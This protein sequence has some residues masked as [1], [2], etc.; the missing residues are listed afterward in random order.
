MTC[1]DSMGVI[2]PDREGEHFYSALGTGPFDSCRD[3][4]PLPRVK[5]Y[6]RILQSLLG[7]ATSLDIVAIVRE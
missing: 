6:R 3:A 2:E 7:L 5:P 4:L 1:D